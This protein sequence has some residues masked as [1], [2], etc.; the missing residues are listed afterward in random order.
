[1]KKKTTVRSFAARAVAMLLVLMTLASLFTV[2]A[3]AATNWPGVSS[4][5]Y[6]EFT[7][8]KKINVYRYSNFS[9]RG[10]SSPAKTYNAY[11][12]QNDVCRIIA[13]NANYIKLQY[14]TSSGYKTGYVRRA[15][16][17][18]V[19]A[20]LAQVTSAGKATTYTKPGGKSYGYVAAGDRV[21]HCGTSGNYVAVIYQAKSGSRAYKLGYV[22][23]SDYN[24]IIIKSTAPAPAAPASNGLIFPLKGNITRSSNVKTNGIYCD[25]RTGG[26][27]GV[28]APANGT[29]KFY[30]SYGYVG[31]TKTLIS[32]GNWIEFTT[33]D[34]TYVIK[35]CHMNSF[36]GVNLQIPS[37]LTARYS[38]SEKTC[39]TIHLATK[40][41][42]QGTL[43]GYSGYTGNAS[44]HHLHLE[45]K[46][47]GTPVNPVN[48]FR[49]W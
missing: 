2:T 4:G 9:A 32:Y 20:P 25:Y 45:V 38:A 31:N 39:Y 23:V 47:N 43:L 15:D 24:G 40:T 18:G 26:S 12:D 14:P 46:K 17:I 3:F 37:S 29:A 19:N 30:Q 21:Y 6:C 22:T 13:F 5:A 49:T 33:A 27:V 35:M 1:M 48:V 28:Y 42:T 34:G 44:G 8:Q 7:A 36:N 11:I 41:V 16:V 10:T